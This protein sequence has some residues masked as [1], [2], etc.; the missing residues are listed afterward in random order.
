MAIRSRA[1]LGA[2]AVAL[3]GVALTG[4]LPADAAPA[5]RLDVPLA[6]ILSPGSGSRAVALVTPDP[7]VSRLGDGTAT[8]PLRIVVSEAA[9]SGD[10]AGWAVTVQ[11]SEFLDATGNRLSAAALSDADNEVSQSGGGGTATAV[12][13]LGPLDQPRTVFADKGEDPNRLYTGTFTAASRLVLAPPAGTP[14]GIYTSVLTVTLI[15]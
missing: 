9:A 14:G 7:I 11:A 12:S 10:G 4:V 5:T 8:V 6:A 1:R 3:A 2:G 15:S 13:D